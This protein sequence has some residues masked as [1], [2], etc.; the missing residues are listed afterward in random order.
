MIKLESVTISYDNTIL[1]SVDITIPQNKITFII[2]KNGSG[3]S[4][5]LHALSGLKK[6]NQ[7]NITIDNTT[8]NKKT[9]NKEMRN[10]VGIVFQ[11]PDNQIIFNKVYDDIKFTLENMDIEKKDIDGIIK[12]A[13]TEVDMLEH[14]NKNPYELSLGQKQRIAIASI[15]ALKPQ[16]MLFDESTAMLDINGKKDIYDLFIK[17]KKKKTGVLATTNIMD[18]LVLADDVLIIDNKKIYKYTKEEIIDDLNILTKHGLTASFLLKAMHIL[19]K[20]GKN[21]NDED[22]ILKELAA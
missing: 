6:I 10:K 12:E 16:Y 19:K 2:G 18:E 9:S 7:G 21:I 14:I 17:L 3:K 11:N 13:L 4:T 15:L 20:K 8:I 1:E 22:D 5:L